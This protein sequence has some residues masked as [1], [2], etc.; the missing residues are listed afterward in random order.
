LTHGLQL[1]FRDRARFRNALAGFTVRQEP[2]LRGSLRDLVR[3][4]RTCANQRAALDVEFWA[5]GVDYDGYDNH[6]L[7]ISPPTSDESW[8]V[9]IYRWVPTT[10][11]D[12]DLSLT[13]ECQVP[14]GAKVAD[15]VRLFNLASPQTINDWAETP[16][17]Q[18]LRGTPFVVTN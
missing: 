18:P 11:A 16:Q 1:G 14:D 4:M 13:L 15:F 7:E 2:R 12:P 9:T 10:G 3:V 17:G 5:L 6:V 8:T